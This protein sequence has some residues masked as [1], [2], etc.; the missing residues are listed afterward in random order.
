ME[1]LNTVLD[2]AFGKDPHPDHIATWD[3]C[4]DAIQSI[5]DRHQFRVLEYPVWFWE[6]TDA[7]QLAREKEVTLWKVQIGAE[8]KKKRQAILQH[9]SQL[10][11]IIED[12]PDGFSLSDEMLEHFYQE[13]EIFFEYHDAI[14]KI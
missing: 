9:A 4:M 11:K 12:D 10:G 1:I 8:L 6:R 5:A 2:S 13:E 7:S 14:R 3:L